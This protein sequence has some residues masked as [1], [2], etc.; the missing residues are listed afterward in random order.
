MTSVIASSISES[1]LHSFLPHTLTLSHTRSCSTRSRLCC[2]CIASP[3][4]RG[5][6]ALSVTLDIISLLAVKV[7]SL[8]FVALRSPRAFPRFLP[9]S[10]ALFSRRP[11]SFL[12]ASRS[13]DQ[14]EG[15][16]RNQGHRE[17]TP[18]AV[19]GASGLAAR[20]GWFPLGYR[21]GFSQW[22]RFMFRDRRR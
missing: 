1:L 19:R 4:D 17:R 10:V 3:G 22:V 21:E 5:F 8:R 11:A 14:S 9:Q 16:A 20:P 7:S 15:G 12:M 2:F 6:L 18:D 13:I